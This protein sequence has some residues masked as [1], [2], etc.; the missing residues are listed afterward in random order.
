MWR[1]RG[2]RRKSSEYLIDGLVTSG[3]ICRVG[4]VSVALLLLLL[5][6]AQR[7]WGWRGRRDG[8]HSGC[9]EEGRLVKVRRDGYTV[10]VGVE[11]ANF[12]DTYVLLDEVVG[13]S[14]KFEKI[15]GLWF[16]HVERKYFVVTVDSFSE[17]VRDE[18]WV[19]LEYRE[20]DRTASAKIRHGGSR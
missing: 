14:K 3:T 16:A 9:L 6:L 19:T 12:E 7:P 18:I 17:Y 15:A 11:C 1:G 10:E 2:I 20:V 4:S 8:I 13:I 5:R